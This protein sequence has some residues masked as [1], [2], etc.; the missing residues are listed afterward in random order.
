MWDG[1]TRVN[2]AVV[3]EWGEVSKCT[4]GLVWFQGIIRHMQVNTCALE[5]AARG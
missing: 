5:Q 3:T 2:M 4:N 1:S